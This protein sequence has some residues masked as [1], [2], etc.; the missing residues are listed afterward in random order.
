MSPG[1]LD[2]ILCGLH[3]VKNPNIIVGLDTPDD[4]AVYK[5][6]ENTAL[7]QTVDF[8]TPIVD[9]PYVFGQI[10]AANSLSD[11][12]AMGAEPI[13][14]LNLVGFPTDKLDKSILKEILRGGMDKM[15]EAGVCLVGGHSIDDPEIK[16][17]LAVTGLVHPEKVLTKQGART[18]DA[19]LITKPLGIGIIATALKAGMASSSAVQDITNAMV[20]LNKTAS[21]VIQDIGVHACTDITGFGLIGHAM[22]V[23]RSSSKAV[24]LHAST[25]PVFKD[26]LE[27]A[28]MGLVPMGAQNNRNFYDPCVVYREH[29]SP[30][31]KDILYDPQTSGGL[32]ITVDPEKKDRLIERCKEREVEVFLVGEVLDEPAEKIV[33]E[34]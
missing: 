23:A 4:S 16:Y 11:I 34:K 20:T 5:I 6:N 12:Y 19:V 13:T 2:D 33:I 10:A 9:D 32:F 24:C 14:A 26:A 7:V 1:V 15:A 3:P 29:I 17:G 30:E 18:G 21:E 27:Y 22:E 8:F 25:V 28:S 31:M